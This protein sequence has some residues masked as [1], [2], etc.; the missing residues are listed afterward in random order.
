MEEVTAHER[1]MVF[2]EE[3]LVVDAQLFLHN[4]MEEKGVS[5][6]DLARAIGVSRARVSQL[7]SDDCKNFTIRIFARAAHALGEKVEFDCN[8]FRASRTRNEYKSIAGREYA[9]VVPMWEEMILPHH[10]SRES[11][12]KID[13]FIENYTDR[14]R[15]RVYA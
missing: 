6:A 10:E 3:A 2:A 14:S 15:N 4:L 1:E 11:C 8:H 13:R 7:F 5:R 9:N 12:G